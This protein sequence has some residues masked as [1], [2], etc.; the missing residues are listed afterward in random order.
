MPWKTRSTK[1]VP[2]PEK[3]L[4]EKQKSFIC[5]AKFEIQLIVKQ[6]FTQNENGVR[7]NYD[8]Q[9]IGNHSDVTR[10][11]LDQIELVIRAEVTKK[12][13]MDKMVDMIKQYKNVKYIIEQ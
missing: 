2:K 10:K 4:Q 12:K 9:T 11:M 13:V 7:V 3:G 5:W 8:A 1:V 6:F